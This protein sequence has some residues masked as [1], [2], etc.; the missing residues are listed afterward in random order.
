[1]TAGQYENSYEPLMLLREQNLNVLAN[2]ENWDL[3]WGGDSG[4][5]HVYGMRPNGR[6]PR[7]TAK[8]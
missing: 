7:K 2:W 8:L 1:M 4:N 3:T 6:V 5:I